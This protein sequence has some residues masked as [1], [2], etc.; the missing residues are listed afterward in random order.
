MGFINKIKDVL[1]TEEK[2]NFTYF[3]KLVQNNPLEIVLEADITFDGD[4]DS[5]IGK[6]ILLETDN[7]VIDGNGFS[8][9]ANHKSTIFFIK[10]S[11]ITLKNI[12]FKNAFEVALFNDAEDT[13]IIECSFENIKGQAIM[14][15]NGSLNLSKSVF[16]SNDTENSGGAI[17]NKKAYLNIDDC[18]FNYN[19]SLGPG[20]ALVNTYGNVKI[21]NCE[22]LN[23]VSKDIGGAI[24]NLNEIEI[25]NSNFNHNTS[26]REG[27][28]IY[29]NAGA[30]LDISGCEFSGLMNDELYSFN[31][32]EVQFKNCKFKDDEYNLENS[33]QW[34]KSQPTKNF[35]YLNELVRKRSKE[36]VLDADI[37]FEESEKYLFPNGVSINKNNVVID[38]NGHYISG[39]NKS[40]IFRCSGKNI[41]LKNI[42]FKDATSQDA[43]IVN[44][45]EL[46]IVDCKFMDNT[47]LL[48]GGTIINANKGKLSIRK[49]DFVN[50]K[51]YRSGG[52]IVNYCELS[53]EDSKFENNSS[54]E[55]AGAIINLQDCILNIDNTL[56]INNSAGSYGKSI[57]N[58]GNLN[59]IKSSFT[60]SREDE[61]C[62]ISASIMEMNECHFN[63]SVEE[64]IEDSH[65]DQINTLANFKYLN[66]LIQSGRKEI[67]L[68][69]DFTLKD[70][71]ASFYNKGI[72]INVDELVIDGDN[73]FIDANHK[74]RIF[75]VINGNVIF[76]NII[77]KNAFA[78]KGAAIL[79]NWGNIEFINCKF[80][81][82]ASN[83]QGGAVTA[84]SGNLKMNKCD[85]I[86]NS[87]GNAGGAIINNANLEIEE[88]NFRNNRA[89]LGGAI[90]NISQINIVNCQFDTN[91]AN[92]DG[93]A[94]NNYNMGIVNVSN[95]Y[96][97]NNSAENAGAVFN[98]NHLQVNDSRFNNNEAI[99]RG[100]AIMTIKT[101]KISKCI[102][103]ENI[104]KT[105]GAGIAHLGN[106]TEVFSSKF[107]KNKASQTGGAISCK[108]FDP[109]GLYYED[110]SFIENFPNNIS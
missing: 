42:I 53:I 69:A 31:K 89:D 99:N 106:F 105:V 97:V 81:D 110:C 70:N 68:E 57:L 26:R 52:A 61:I 108:D 22:F 62:G 56:F 74:A 66:D 3:N 77:F 2:R 102:F 19:V 12:N 6:G 29:N 67:I 14:N 59:L 100:G 54:K 79:N 40:S 101:L 44:L 60:K 71:E 93:G 23:N 75:N 43:A 72:A 16:L 15:L 35:K 36:I 48:T 13:N 47:G 9:D 55:E 94:I 18:E 24:Y 37:V 84:L 104:S 90:Y 65:Q 58:L 85:F 8:I 25:L 28:S 88:C 34:V 78:S 86:N 39:N 41:T 80:L 27:K 91:V 33:S 46:E 83:I 30:Y 51:S 21:D 11:N 7:L 20:G 92:L 50:N 73:H 107:I 32:S 96:F 98:Y 45:G 76:K 103:E 49:T 4:D 64:H 109:S 5:F 95:T 82:N 17:F 10:G 63:F 87:T 38:G 1:S